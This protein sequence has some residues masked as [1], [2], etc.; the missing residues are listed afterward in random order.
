MS[1]QHKMKTRYYKANHSTDSKVIGRRYPQ[2]SEAIGGSWDVLDSRSAYGQLASW[3]SPEGVPPVGSLVLSKG[4]KATDVLSASMFSHHG[5]I[6]SP[7]AKAIFEQYNLG[8]NWFFPVD[9]RYKEQT[10]SYFILHTN[11]NFIDDINWDKSEFSF[12]RYSIERKQEEIVEVINLRNKEAYLEL[13]DNRKALNGRYLK[14]SQIY[15]K[16]DFD[17]SRD[18]IAFYR[19]A[20]GT[21]VSERLMNG[22]LENG[23]TGLVFE[24]PPVFDKWFE[25]ES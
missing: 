7:K 12:S 2:V 22:L 14:A 20:L 19:I 18:M 5:F 9:V 11:N 4:A 21:L 13:R 3:V 23:I 8:A 25:N 15:L 6:L 1:H 17:S 24:K 16:E 10:L